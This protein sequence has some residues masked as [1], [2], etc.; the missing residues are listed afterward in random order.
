MASHREILRI[1]RRA[2]RKKYFRRAVVIILLFLLLL[3]FVA[4]YFWNIPSFALTRLI[5]I[6][7]EKIPTAHL[8]GVIDGVLS[9]EYL[10]LFRRRVNW[11]YP[12]TVLLD[13][14]HR[15]FP[16]LA[17]I[18][19]ASPVFGTLQVVVEERQP[20]ALGCGED[21]CYFVDNSGLF[22]APAPQFSNAPLFTLTGFSSPI[23][24]GSRPLPMADFEH[25]LNL[26]ATINRLLQTAPE[27]A[28]QTVDKVSLGAP[29]D[30]N[31]NIRNIRQDSHGWYL[32]VARRDSL[33]VVG[34]RLVATLSS[35]AF[36]AE[37]DLLTSALESLDIRF[38]RKVF[39]KFM[40]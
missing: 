39:Y 18:N 10:G 3:S 37:Y 1:N 22:Y 19:V 34:S 15:Q 31:F 23:S 28:N 38:E 13:I 6:G 32:L 40:P 14:L 7:N 26:R 8:T 9:G 35:P 27:F 17:L 11:F 21:Q 16:E 4:W 2:R 30:Y 24:V 25:L 33:V 29:V 20:V 5:I 36:L 12:R